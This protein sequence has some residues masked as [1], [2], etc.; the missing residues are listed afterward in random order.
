MFSST[1]VAKDQR[2]VNGVHIIVL[3]SAGTL[4]RCK[5]PHS[6]TGW[7]AHCR[8]VTQLIPSLQPSAETPCSPAR[9]SCI[10]GPCHCR[11]GLQTRLRGV[12]TQPCE[13]SCLVSRQHQSCRQSFY[14]VCGK[15]ETKMHYS[16]SAMLFDCDPCYLLLVTAIFW[17][18][19]KSVP[20]FCPGAPK[21]S[22]KLRATSAAG[23][24]GQ[25]SG[26]VGHSGLA[27]RGSAL[28]ALGAG[29]ATSPAPKLQAQQTLR[30]MPAATDEV[31]VVTLS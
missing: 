17:S 3:G 5:A 28:T 11:P 29:H 20:G 2:D 26:T 24:A 8:G 16:A 21:D 9:R 22:D 31:G 12:Q 1:A 4:A 18:W 13:P 25:P 6:L 23:Q 14:Q 15:A 7:M 10:L 27:Q 19:E 30:V